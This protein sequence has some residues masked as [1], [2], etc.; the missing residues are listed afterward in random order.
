MNPQTTD[1]A[2]QSPDSYVISLTQV[3]RQ[4]NPQ[5][6]NRVQRWRIAQG[7]AETVW[8]TLSTVAAA[9]ER[10]DVHELQVEGRQE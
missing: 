8:K 1:I 3:L 7:F 10:V 4:R 2:A 9:N 6:D 5:A